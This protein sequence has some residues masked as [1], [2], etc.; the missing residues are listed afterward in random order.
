MIDSS[1]IITLI[2][3][4]GRQDVYVGVMKGAIATVNP[5]LK[6]IDLTHEIPP[7]NIV[8]ARYCLLNAYPYF[9]VDTVHVAVV[10]PGV[11]SHRRGVAIA[12][13]DGY[14]VCPDN[15]L[16]S[17]ILEMRTAIAAVE[18]TNSQYWRNSNPSQ[19]FHGR[20]IFAPV[21]AHLAS[22]VPLAALGTKIDPDS[23]VRFSL[24]ALQIIDNQVIGCIQ[25]IDHFGN[26]ISNIPGSLV[27][28][29]TWQ[30]IVKEQIIPS[31]NTYSD[32]ETGKTIALVGSHG[33][34][35]IA[36]NSGNA[37]QKLQLNIE[38]T[39]KIVY[40]DM[41]NQKKRLNRNTNYI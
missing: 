39:I 1:R 36:V 32:V 20:D 12:F 35:E 8:A 15:G 9:P 19:T 33:W 41:A 28:N 17:G 3:D 34:I 38:N 14:L 23:L 7:Q 29:K 4:F 22:G 11:G 16:C 5:K 27:S 13:N 37:C 2:T 40:G 10:D 31:G 26:L 21:G 6:V 25:Y 24:P 30:V 18:L